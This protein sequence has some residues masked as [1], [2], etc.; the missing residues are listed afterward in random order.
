MRKIVA[1]LL[2][3]GVGDLSLRPLADRVGTSARLLIYHF[4]SKEALLAAA[5]AEVRCEVDIA[6]TIRAR[7]VRPAS[8][9][10][11]I[12][13]F[14]DW[15][16]E[17]ANQ[18]YFRL[19]FEVDGLTLF[20]RVSLSRETQQANSETW[21]RLIERG[22]ATLPGD[23]VPPTIATLLMCATKG[24]LQEFLMTGDLEHTTAAIEALLEELVAEASARLE[25]AGA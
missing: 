10:A 25:R 22:V 23:G 16:T 15:S 7:Q 4:A 11:M 8:L 14:W 21:T 9:R 19:L 17:A 12:M 18:R 6:L 3:H 1:E 13:M 20:N 24:L 5:L 2:E